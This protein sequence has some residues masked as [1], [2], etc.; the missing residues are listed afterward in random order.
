MNAPMKKGQNLNW[1][2]ASVEL[3]EVPTI[4]PGQDALSS[5]IAAVLPT[6]AVPLAANVAT[7]QAKE[8]MFAGKLTAAE[9]AYQ[10]GDD[11]GSQSVGQV[12]SMLGQMGQQA[13]Q[14][15]QQA[16][17]P[18]QAG[19]GMFGSMMQQAMQMAQGAG[20]G[21]SSGGQ[22]APAAGG[23]PA[24]AGQGPAG[25]AGQPAPGQ[26]REDGSLEQRVERLE[27]RAERED[28]PNDQPAPQ[29][30][31]R[32][33]L[34]RADEGTLAGGPEAGGAAPAPVAPPE[35]GRHS[36]DEDIARRL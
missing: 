14:M 5:T 28:T 2:P 15:A 21:Q 29:R 25:M 22:G 36:G 26:P 20:G 19:G 6:L 13:G 12:V 3:P 34:Q 1:D 7:L 18:A 9:T 23:A 33:P 11:Q 8:G 27:E 32:Q 24:G 10:T 30:E 17:A 31:E 35:T 4:Q 16:G